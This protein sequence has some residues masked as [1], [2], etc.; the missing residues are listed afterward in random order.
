[1][2]AALKLRCKPSGTIAH[3]LIMVIKAISGIED[4]ALHVFNLYFP[5][6][7]LLL[8]T[9]NAVAAAEKLADKANKGI[10]IVTKF[11]LNLGDLVIL[12][13]KM[14]SLFPIH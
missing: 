4:E 14:R 2:L 5:G 8:N 1:M 10:L 3:S 12:F 13:Q 9:Y 6:A 7:T 11:C